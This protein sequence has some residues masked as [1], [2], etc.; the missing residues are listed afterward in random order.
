MTTAADVL[1]TLLL[2][3]RPPAERSG[4]KGRSAYARFAVTC[5]Q[6]GLRATLPRASVVRTTRPPVRSDSR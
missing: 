3:E 1:L 4:P 5:I 2:S 6:E